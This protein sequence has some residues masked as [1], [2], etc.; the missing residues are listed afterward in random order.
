MTGALCLLPPQPVLLLFPSERPR[1][2][3]EYATGSYSA[4]AYF[5]SKLV[6][7]LPLGFATAVLAFLI[8]FWMVQLHGSFILDVLI[9]WLI[10]LC[11]AS[12]ALFFGCLAASAQQAMQAAP[13]IFVPQILF[14]GL[15]V[16]VDQIP[17]WLRWAQYLCS[18]KY[19]IDLFL[20]NEFGSSTCDPSQRKACEKLLASSDVQE[21]LWW[22][23]GLIMIGIF[24]VFRLLGLFVLTRRARGFALA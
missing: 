24:L 6:T 10:G 14:A 11:A 21:S 15:F 18:L 4:T 16:K 9:A 3:R 19:G 20:I 13:I 17:V 1:F 22:A 5:W 8:T 2:V 7:E 12:T 23:Y